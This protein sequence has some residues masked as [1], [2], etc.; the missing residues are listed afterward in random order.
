MTVWSLSQ[1]GNVSS[2][3]GE[4]SYQP[5]E[6]S[7]STTHGFCSFPKAGMFAQQ[8]SRRMLQ[9]AQCAYQSPHKFLR[10]RAVSAP[11]H[12]LQLGSARHSGP[13]RE[14]RDRSFER[15]SRSLQGNRIRMSN[16]GTEVFQQA[17]AVLQKKTKDVDKQ[18]P[19]VAQ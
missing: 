2:R 8:I 5:R 14:V 3:D 6:H 17:V 9:L 4:E 10:A 18:I 15:M 16:R 1:Y 11:S 7:G 19:V 13:R 12:F